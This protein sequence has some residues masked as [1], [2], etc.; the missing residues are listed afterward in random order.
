MIGPNIIRIFIVIEL[1]PD[2]GFIFAKLLINVGIT[3]D[4]IIFIFNLKAIRVTVR[5]F[6]WDRMPKYPLGSRTDL[7]NST[8]SKKVTVH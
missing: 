7:P 6:I 4:A 8:C 1:F 5:S 3:A 2:F